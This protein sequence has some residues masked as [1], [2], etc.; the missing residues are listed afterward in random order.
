MKILVLNAGSSTLKCSLIAVTPAGEN[1]LAEGLIEWQ[2]PARPA[3]AE[4][5]SRVGAPG[6]RATWEVS[7][8]GP[9]RL[10]GELLQRLVDLDPPVLRGLDEIAAV[11]H[12]VVHGGEH[13]RDSTMLDDQ[14]VDA[15]AK[16]A[17]LA[18]LHNPPAVEGIRAARQA[19]PGVPQVAV[20]DTAFHATLPPAAYV[21]PLPYAWYSDWGIRRYGF[22]GISHAYVAGRAA[23]LL[24]RPLADLRLVTCHLGNGCSLAAVAGGRSVDTTMGFTPLDGVAMG[25]RSGSLDPGILIYLQRQ[26]GLS[27][28]ALDQALTHEAG[29]LGVSGLSGDMRTLLEAAA[30]GQARARLAID[31]FVARVRSGIAAMAAALGGLDALVFTAGI[32][33]HAAPIRAQVCAPLSFMGVAVDP[34]RNAAVRPDG[35]IAP[36]GAAIRVL[37]IQTQEDRMI[38][39]ETAR[40]LG[41]APAAHQE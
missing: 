36:A 14:V 15:I 34:A 29:L 11:G 7:G 23:A 28:D 21:Y 2:D 4:L 22:H 24:A 1:E 35:D 33:E 37:V 20:F 6:N 17:V 9:E 18:P 39:R 3:R 38:A 41:L 12:R 30:A 8:A 16:L 25:T 19:L 27:A 32:G 13:Y 5:E 31:I 10:V 26:H 40:V